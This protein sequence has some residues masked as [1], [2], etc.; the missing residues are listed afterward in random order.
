MPDTINQGDSSPVV[1]RMVLMTGSSGDWQPAFWLRVTWGQIKSG[2]TPC[3]APAQLPADPRYATALEPP[4][5]LTWDC[6]CGVEAPLGAEL[7]PEVV[8]PPGDLGPGGEAEGPPEP[9]DTEELAGGAEVVALAPATGVVAVTLTEVPP[10]GVDEAPRFAPATG[11]VAV[12]LT[13][14]PPEGFETPTEAEPPLLPVPVDT[15]TV[16]PV[17]SVAETLAGGTFTG[18]GTVT[19]RSEVELEVESGLNSEPAAQTGGAMSKPEHT[20]AM[21]APPRAARP[22]QR[23]SSRCGIGHDAKEMPSQPQPGRTSRVAGPL[24]R[25]AMGR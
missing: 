9:T 23:E 13:E 22:I 24:S 20:R 14:V 12:T 11:V 25:S 6:A 7:E 8:E 2:S 16:V 3:S 5:G 19:L 15:V 17:G 1:A 4:P 21:A 18:S 10:E